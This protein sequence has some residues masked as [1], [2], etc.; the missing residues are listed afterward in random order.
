MTPSRVRVDAHLTDLLRST[1][2][3]D[4]VENQVPELY[5]VVNGVELKV[6][7]LKPDALRALLASGVEGVEIGLGE[8]HLGLVGPATRATSFDVAIRVQRVGALASVS[9]PLESA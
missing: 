5:V 9:H 6:A 7:I 4:V 2:L 8:W 3:G 1:L